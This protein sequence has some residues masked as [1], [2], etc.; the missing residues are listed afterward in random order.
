MA[1]YAVVFLGSTPIGGPLVGWL[2][3]SF[4]ARA[5]LAVGAGAALIAA[6]V[7]VAARR[8]TSAVGL[9]AAEATSG[10]TS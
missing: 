10:G 5:G 1:L 4:G 9:R 6:A 7:A 8:R 2:S 3:G